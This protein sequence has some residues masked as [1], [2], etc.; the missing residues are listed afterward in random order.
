ML[1][2]LN[3]DPKALIDVQ[4]TEFSHDMLGRWVCSTWPEV[5]NNGGDP[6]DVVVL[7]AGMFGGYIADK[8][9]RRGENLGLRVLVIEAGSFLLPSHVQNMPRLGLNSPSEQVVAA[10]AQDPG[11]QNLV[12]G[13]P[14]HSNQAFPGL[15]YCIGGRSLFWGGWSPRLT[16]ADLGPR[17]AAQATWPADAAS[18]L[19]ATYRAVEEEMGVWP[20]TDYISGPLYDQLRSRFEGVI[21]AGNLV[22]GA[23]QSLWDRAL[24][25]PLLAVQ[26][27]AP[28]SG[29]FPCD[30]AWSASPLSYGIW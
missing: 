13:H 2:A 23:G 11:A 10:N 6:F 1:P 27:K 20:T 18:Y 3:P 15:A 5:S 30:R 22:W 12:W 9:Y 19:L 7:G 28:E 25:A 21:G 17:P 8:L 26:S 24:R 29:L 16:S 14:W 4:Q